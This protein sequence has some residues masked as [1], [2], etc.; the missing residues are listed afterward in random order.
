MTN[1]QYHNFSF[2]G[3][4]AAR[5]LLSLNVKVWFVLQLYI[6]LIWANSVITSLSVDWPQ[7]FRM[8]G[9]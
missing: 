3:R 5:K 1:I 6:F 7:C 4:Y 8:T 9:M 2:Q